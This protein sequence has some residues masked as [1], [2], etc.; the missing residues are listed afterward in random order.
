M[1]HQVKILKGDFSSLRFF[2][3]E[4]FGA[5]INEYIMW[6]HIFGKADSP[7]CGKLTSKITAV[8]NKNL[9]R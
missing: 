9:G 2:W 7:C 5:S 6:L 3:C 4:G 8:D 1:Y